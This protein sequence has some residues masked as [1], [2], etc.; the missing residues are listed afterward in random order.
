MSDTFL[1]PTLVGPRFADHAIPLE[2]LKDLAVLEEFVV[3]VAKALYLKDNPTRQRMP[4]GFTDGVSLKL[5]SVESGSA[6]PVIALAVAGVSLLPPDNQVYLEKARDA[7]VNVIAAADRQE[8]VVDLVPD[9]TLNYFDRLGRSLR[10]GE[11]IHFPVTGNSS[12]AR[13]N[14][15]TRLRLMESSSLKEIKNEVNA[16]GTIPEADQDNMSFELQLPDGHKVKAPIASEHLQTILAAFNAYQSGAR[17]AVQGIG[18]YRKGADRLLGIDSVEHVTLLDP[19][20]VPARLDELRMLRD[21][22]LDGQGTAPSPAQL[23]WLSEWF[24]T[25]FPDELPLPLTFPTVEGG[26]RFEWAIGRVDASVDINLQGREGYWH[27]HDSAAA[28]SNEAQVDLSTEAGWKSLAARVQQLC[29]GS[30]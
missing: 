8:S 3:E 23:D 27:S 10:S 9:K 26:V 7:I 12:I 25:S 1:R 15:E 28:D 2:V 18:R 11:E 13:L 19:L 4:R 22:W 14:P 5:S 21:G 29:K 16:R 24:S 17:I 20:D 6:I 30:L